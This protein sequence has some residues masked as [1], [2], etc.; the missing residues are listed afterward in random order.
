MVLRSPGRSQMQVARVI[1]I[2]LCVWIHCDVIGAGYNNQR[3]ALIYP[4]ADATEPGAGFGGQ[5]PAGVAG[6]EFAA[7]PVPAAV[8]AGTV[9]VYGTPLVRPSNTAYT[10][11][12]SSTARPV[13]AVVT[14]LS[15]VTVYDRTGAPPVSAGG[16][17]D[18]LT[19]PS[20]VSVATAVGG[21]GSR[22][23]SAAG[24]TGAVA[25]DTWPAPLAFRAVTV[26]VYGVPLARP[27]TR[28]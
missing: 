21:P 6:A 2:H 8:V 24:V 16:W 19:T 23:A 3:R 5:A 15:A 22:A 7:G 11:F 1:R 4:P 27:G 20:P 9:N 25:V 26:N 14:P 12:F 18:T 10:F 13:T 28:T 17:N